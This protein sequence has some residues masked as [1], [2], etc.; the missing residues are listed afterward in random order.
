MCWPNCC[1]ATRLAD[2]A[3]WTQ[4]NFQ[5]NNIFDNSAARRDLGFAYTVRWEDGARRLVTW[6]DANGKVEDSDLD[7]F[8]DNLLAAWDKALATMAKSWATTTRQVRP[9][10]RKSKIKTS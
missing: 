4:T 1:P 9:R 6:L 8:E 10:G 3:H 7:H 2:A 5:F